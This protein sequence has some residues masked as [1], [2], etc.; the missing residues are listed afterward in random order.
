MHTA[1]SNVPGH[2]SRTITIYRTHLGHIA[3]SICTNI[4][5]A[6]NSQ[7]L[8][9]IITDLRSGD[10]LDRAQD[11]EIKDAPRNPTLNLTTA[12]N[13]TLHLSTRLTIILTIK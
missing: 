12:V 1:L 7:L 13:S 3:L 10:E 2:A 5:Y 4:Q 11:P 6:H 9:L 8:K